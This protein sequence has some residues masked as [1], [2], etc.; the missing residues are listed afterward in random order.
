[1]IFNLIVNVIHNRFIIS[2]DESKSGHE[3]EGGK[4]GIIAPFK[5]NRI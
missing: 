2:V 3:I 4:P 1:M 5:D